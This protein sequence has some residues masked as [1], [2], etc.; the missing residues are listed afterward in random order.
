M[1]IIY[2]EIVEVIADEGKV[3]TNDDVNYA[4][5]LYLSINDSP[6]NWHEIPIEEVPNDGESTEDSLSN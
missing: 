4:T 1:Q 2:G 3:L 6:S 5:H